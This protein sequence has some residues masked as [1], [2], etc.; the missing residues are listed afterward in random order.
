MKN[1]ERKRVIVRA[2]SLNRL[3]HRYFDLF[4]RYRLRIAH[5]VVDPA[6]FD[7]DDPVRHGLQRSVVR[8]D[9]DRHSLLPAA[10]LQKLQ[11]L[12]AGLVVQR[13]GRLVAEH[14]LRILRERAGDGDAL[15]F[16]ARK[17]RG[18]ILFPV[19]KADQFQN[20]VRVIRMAADLR[21]KLHVFP[22]G[23]ILY[24]IVE[25]EYEADRLPPVER[26]LLLGEPLDMHAVHD[27]LAACRRIHSPENIQKR[28]LARAGRPDD[29]AQFPFFNGEV[30]PVQGVD[31]D[32]AHTVLFSYVSDLDICHLSVTPC[33]TISYQ[34]AY[35]LTINARIMLK[36]FHIRT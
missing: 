28:G 22:G 14:Q 25:L 7:G 23:Q 5:V 20:L 16:A 13:A 18:E 9:D 2:I 15:L 21:R 4:Y 34:N 8:N 30:D 29:H 10:V 19:G 11:N 33:C 1:M 6:V 12:F 35:R 31:R 27:D 32:L 24:E 26:E 36:G 3:I 17:L